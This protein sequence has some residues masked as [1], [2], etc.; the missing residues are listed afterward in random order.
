MRNY[1]I[2]IFT[3]H[4][5]CPHTCVF[6]NQRKITGRET[7]VTPT[8]VADILDFHLQRI[9]RPY[10][11]EAAFYGGSFT[12]LPRELQHGL[13]TPATQRIHTGELNAIRLS[14]R[15]DYIDEE[16]LQ[17]LWSMGVRTIE[18]GAQSFADSV[19]RLAERGHTAEDIR[20]AAELVRRAG[21]TLGIQLMPG[22]PG[23]TLETMRSSLEETLRIQPDVV[24]I[25]PTVVIQETKLAAMYEQG[26]FA[27]LSMDEAVHIAACMKL[28]LERRGIRVIRTGLQSSAELDREGT[29]LAGPY[30]SAFGELV[31]SSLFDHMAECIFHRIG[32]MDGIVV[33]HHT[34]RD[35][36][37]LRGM[38]NSNVKKWQREYPKAKFVFQTDAIFED[39]LRVE[40]N[41]LCYNMDKA[42]L[43]NEVYG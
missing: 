1:I 26:D 40:Y 32:V 34:V 23:D 18:L 19:L 33:V 30:H 41:G 16:N 25:Y 39:S 7:N 35:T 9:T 10:H 31:E 11:I 24:R 17:M 6:C 15:P 4:F 21:F 27:P 36:S 2:P 14:T 28:R 12:A 13:L 3:P 29:V 20:R 42:R 8:M 37:K 38:K 43:G 5:G 22:L